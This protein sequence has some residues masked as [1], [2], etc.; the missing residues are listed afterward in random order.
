MG[1]QNQMCPLHLS[2]NDAFQTVTYLEKWNQRRKQFLSCTVWQC[3]WLICSPVRN[4]AWR[5]REAKW[6]T[7]IGRNYLSGV[8]KCRIL[9]SDTAK[10]T[11]P[12]NML[13][14]SIP[15][16][17][18]SCLLELSVIP[19]CV[20]LCFVDHSCP[21]SPH[22]RDRVGSLVPLA[23]GLACAAAVVR[24]SVC[25]WLKWAI[26]TRAGTW[27]PRMREL[28][29]AGCVLRCGGVGGGQFE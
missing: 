23:P 27:W 14:C 1:L 25:G 6:D 8:L 21:S 13:S 22:W 20:S 28:L 19:V 7:C 17:C 5:S 24:L 2:P 10:S 18:L 3:S 9:T 11:T 12:K 29:G 4:G 15:G 16:L 26:Y